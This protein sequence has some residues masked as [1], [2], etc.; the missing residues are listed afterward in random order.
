MMYI[1]KHVC[2]NVC[3]YVSNYVCIL[4]CKYMYISMYPETIEPFRYLIKTLYTWTCIQL[5]EGASWLSL[6]LTQTR[7]LEEGTR[8]VV[9]THKHAHTRARTSTPSH[10]PPPQFKECNRRRS[11]RKVKKEILV[12]I[13]HYVPAMDRRRSL[14]RTECRNGT[15]R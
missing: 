14:K 6:T 13:C 5:C 15:F 9:L 4:V 7:V 11:E 12:E 8:I 3:I 1:F 2:V 10:P